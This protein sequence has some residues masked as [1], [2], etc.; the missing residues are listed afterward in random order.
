MRILLLGARG[1]VG[2]ELERCLQGLGTVVA[3]DRTHMDLADL[4]RVREA[5]RAVRPG[6]IVNAAA[7]TGV[8]MAESEPEL[9][10]RINAEAPAVMAEEARRL[11]AAMVQYS[12][13]YVFDGSK[14]GPYVETDA[15]APLNVYGHTKLLGEQAV[16]DAAIAHLI[17]RTSWVYGMRGHNFLRTMLRLAAERGEVRVVSD[18]HGAPNW[19]RTVA[20]T[21]ADIL[22]QAEAGGPSWW[23]ENSGLYHLS[24]HG[25]TTW[26]DFAQEIFAA[27]DT[28]CRVAP[29]ATQDY[30]TAARRPRNSQL[31][32]SLVRSRFCR[33]PHWQEALRLCLK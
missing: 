7:Y 8:D 30:P 4:D 12:T 17:L 18:Q 1:Q 19:S 24:C 15:P 25:Q 26:S 23:E 20:Q 5:V 9:A 11:G 3:L 32:S 10:R 6:L 14:D 2:Y 27:T 28:P 22:T 31:D 33:I 21:T 13:D 16:A 29:I